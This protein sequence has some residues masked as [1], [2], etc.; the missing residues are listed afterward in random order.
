MK[1]FPSSGSKIERKYWS[2]SLA[3]SASASHLCF[4]YIILILV[5]MIYDHYYLLLFSK[6]G[7]LCFCLPPVL[8]LIAKQMKSDQ[9]HP[10]FFM[11]IVMIIDDDER[12]IYVNSDLYCY[13]VFDSNNWYFYRIQV[14]SLPCLVS[15]SVTESLLV[16]NFAQI[17]GFVN[18]VQCISLG[19]YMDLSKLILGF[20]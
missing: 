20:L 5:V 12:K 2:Q 4:S 19:C 1:P 3:L 8:E 9:D 10:D 16:L 15:Q 14:P 11:V 7:S 13:V 6:F 18:V 17:V